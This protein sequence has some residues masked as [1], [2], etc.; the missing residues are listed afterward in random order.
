VLH[1][2]VGLREVAGPG[3]RR[4]VTIAIS[5]APILSQIWGAGGDRDGGTMSCRGREVHARLDAGLAE[6]H[7]VGAR[8]GPRPPTPAHAPHAPRGR[9]ATQP[10]ASIRPQ[11]NAT[12]TTTIKRCC[13]VLRIIDSRASRWLRSTF[14]AFSSAFHKSLD[15]RCSMQRPHLILRQPRAR[16]RCAARAGVSPRRVTRALVGE[17]AA[18]ALAGAL[19]RCSTA[20]DAAMPHS[21][22]HDSR[23]LRDRSLASWRGCAACVRLMT[24]QACLVRDN[25]MQRECCSDESRHPEERCVAPRVL[26]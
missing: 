19:E 13:R 16:A 1:P 11:C 15:A 21:R 26:L 23:S 14:A 10:G 17:L 3:S 7:P 12:A 18:G 8:R 4:L 20:R 6:S 24:L 2:C 22:P 25:R 9:G 5:P